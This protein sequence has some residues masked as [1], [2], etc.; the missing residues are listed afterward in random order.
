[1]AGTFTL[2]RLA[3]ARDA[4]TAGFFF[5]AIMMSSL[6]LSPLEEEAAS[7]LLGVRRL[8]G[9]GCLAD[10]WAGCGFFC[11]SFFCADFS[12]TESSSLKGRAE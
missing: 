6:S 5:G 7:V 3:A 2:E 10:F 4:L 12:A 9:A 11:C 1:V 8:E